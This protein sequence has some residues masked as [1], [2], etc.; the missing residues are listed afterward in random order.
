MIKNI[1]LEITKSKLFWILL[2]LFTSICAIYK[3]YSL[4]PYV[5][6]GG[7]FLFV[8]F[9][10]LKNIVFSKKK[11]NFIRILLIFMCVYFLIC[12]VSSGKEVYLLILDNMK[13]ILLYFFI[14]LICLLSLFLFSSKEDFLKNSNLFLILYFNSILLLLFIRG[15]ISGNEETIVLIP[16]Y[17]L[18]I[19][20]SFIFFIL[21]FTWMAFFFYPLLAI[22]LDKQTIM[23]PIYRIKH[24][25]FLIIILI[26]LNLIL[27]DL[28]IL[29]FNFDPMRP[30]SRVLNL[31][32]DYQQGGICIRGHCC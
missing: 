2:I 27:P 3:A 13:E 19:C 8:D 28:A 14:Y 11:Y 31:W 9:V 18:L 6:I 10:F 17:F 24:P 23:K 15:V 5:L 25:L 32:Y 21:P 4:I 7:V 16:V 22:F 1:I 30:D 12:G 26:L 20:I 29:F